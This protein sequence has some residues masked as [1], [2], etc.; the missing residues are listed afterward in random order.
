M[1]NS[2]HDNNN[3]TEHV[4]LFG[5]SDIQNKECMLWETSALFTL[6]CQ[7]LNAVEMFMNFWKVLESMHMICVHRYLYMH[8]RENLCI[9]STGIF[10][11]TLV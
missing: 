9:N 4:I 6:I 11:L 8:E 10:P 1:I 3:I 7:M 2:I 5:S